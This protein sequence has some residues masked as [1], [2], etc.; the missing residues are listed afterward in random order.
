MNITVLA[1][2]VSLTHLYSCL[3]FLRDRRHR[4]VLTDNWEWVLRHDRSRALILTRWFQNPPYEDVEKRRVLLLRL[5]DKY[6]HLVYFDDD[7]SASSPCLDVL[8][9]VDRFWKKQI[10]R[11]RSLYLRPLRGNRLFSEF[12]SQTEN[13]PSHEEPWPIPA[14]PNDLS[15]MRVAWNLGV[16]SYPLRGW[17]ERAAQRL[18]R[19]GGGALSSLTFHRPRRTLSAKQPLVQA[20]FS[21]KGYSPLVARQRALFL[22]LVQGQT[23]VASGFIAKKA[24]AEELTSVK[25]VISPFGWGEVCFRDFEALMYGALMIKPDMTHLET[26]PDVYHPQL[27]VKWDGTD[28]RNK[29]EEVLA[30]GPAEAQRWVDWGWDQWSD[31]WNALP[32]RLDGLLSDWLER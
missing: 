20:R 29:I 7:D 8:P 2:N 10:Y 11:D 23:G 22:E 19:I 14:N 12:Y 18:F 31:S 24:Y 17:R 21:A 27:S 16:G 28:L 4:F 3:P 9:Y 25:A 6:E 5:R 13:F 26:F 30:L 32:S 15:K 1:P